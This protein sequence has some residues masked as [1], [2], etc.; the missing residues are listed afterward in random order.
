MGAIDML[1]ARLSVKDQQEITAME[2][3]A[4]VAVGLQTSAPLVSQLPNGAMWIVSQM[5]H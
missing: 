4:S 2:H 5:L 1:M 3:S